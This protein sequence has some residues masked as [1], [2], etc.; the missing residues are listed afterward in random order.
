MLFTDKNSKPGFTNRDHMYSDHGG[1]GVVATRNSSLNK[2][3][4][5][6]RLNTTDTVQVCCRL[7]EPSGGTGGHP[8]TLFTPGLKSFSL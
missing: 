5:L 6:K 1:G 3:S 7:R 4:E 2:A 8:N